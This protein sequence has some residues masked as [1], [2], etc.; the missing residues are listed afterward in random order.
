M[1]EEEKQEQPEAPAKMRK[2]CQIMVM[3]PCEDDAVALAIKKQIDD[4]VKDVKDKA[5]NF[6]INER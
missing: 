5:Y 1:V 4:V 6:S 3:F 2:A